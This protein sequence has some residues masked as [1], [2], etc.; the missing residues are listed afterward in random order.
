MKRAVPNY[1]N[2][3]YF[4]NSTTLMTANKSIYDIVVTEKNKIFFL[5]TAT[6]V[7]GN[8]LVIEDGASVIGLL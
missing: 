8:I 6:V 3:I 1:T 7:A 2:T 4:K 5:G